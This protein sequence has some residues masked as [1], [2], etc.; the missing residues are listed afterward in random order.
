MRTATYETPGSLRLRLSLPVGQIEVETVTGT[1]THVELEAVSRDMEEIVDEAR[2]DCRERGEGH[3]VI[4][5]VQTRFGFFVSIGRS[6]DIRLR[7]TCPVGA[8]LEVMTKSA[9]LRARGEFGTVDMKT[10]SGDASI[11]DARGDVKYKS[12]SGDL[13][14]EH[15]G[16]SM[17]AQTASG[18]V[19]VSEVDGDLTVQL[20]SGDVWV[21]DARASVSANTVSG[22][23]KFDAVHSGTMELRSVSG[24]IHL[25]VRRGCRIYVDA[26]TVS[27]AT[28]S[29][30][31]LSDAPTDAGESSDEGTLVE[32]RAKTVS[33]DIAI[34]RAPALTGIER[35]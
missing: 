25:G 29:E 30:L 16:G 1:T 18:D 19:A 11:E 4:V 34:M 3:E 32:I 22:D 7:I 21:R 33:G 5:E 9:D 17:Q 8:D 13:H 28:T 10:A 2:I 31:D 23:Q 35:A 24:D 12:A 6:H 27:G 26:N 20:V 15:A 14:V